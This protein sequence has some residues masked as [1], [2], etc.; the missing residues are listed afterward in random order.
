[1]LLI[2]HCL[3]TEVI[4][5]PPDTETVTGSSLHMRP[6]EKIT[7]QELLYAIMLRSA[8]DACHAVAVH[9]AGN[10]L[11]FAKLMNERAKQLGCNKT[12]FHNPHGLNDDKHKI[13]ARDL[14]KIACAAMRYPEFCEVVKQRKHLMVRSINQ[15][16]RWLINH[17]RWLWHDPTADGIKT[18]YTN[19]AGQ[20]YVGSATRNGIR[21]ITVIMGSNDWRI[22]HQ[23]M[24]KWA[25]NEFV[26]RTILKKG[27]TGQT[28]NVRRGDRDSVDTALATGLVLLQPKGRPIRVTQKVVIEPNLTAPIQAREKVGEL[29][30]SDG[31]GWEK[32]IPMLA[33]QNIGKVTI[34]QRLRRGF[35]PAGLLICGCLTVGLVIRKRAKRARRSYSYV[36][37]R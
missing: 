33:T 4:T 3:P 18:G 27:Q 9:I 30:V 31:K 15:E 32:H 21:V 6:G 37:Y 28:L 25:Y 16:D 22:D 26:P 23:A 2:E 20:C 11:A 1:M 36:R 10:D 17:N 14:G 13:S 34:T 8:N 12:F 19:P 5:A 35:W 29:V 24:L 7:V